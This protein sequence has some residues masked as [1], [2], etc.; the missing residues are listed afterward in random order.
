MKE[1]IEL[2]KIIVIASGALAALWLILI[3]LPGSQLRAFFLEVYS[4]GL[5]VISGLL[6]LYV[7]NPI[8]LIPDILPLIGQADDA[9]A[10]IGAVFSGSFGW[11]SGILATKVEN[12]IS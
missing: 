5:Y 3:A 8:D 1:L 4:K 6:I 9:A 7:I 10:V 11:L 12:R 2:F